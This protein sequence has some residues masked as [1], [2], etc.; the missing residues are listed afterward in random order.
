V[1]IGDRLE[2]GEEWEKVKRLIELARNAHRTELTP[3]RKQR[4]RQALVER[5]ERAPIERLE[6]ARSRRRFAG[7]FVA[8]ASTMLLVGLLLRL[9]GGGLPWVGQDSAELARK[10]AA[11]QIVAE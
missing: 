7:A 2:Q 8:G 6:R 3:E 10:Q 9:V 11:P 5:F 4:I 1:K